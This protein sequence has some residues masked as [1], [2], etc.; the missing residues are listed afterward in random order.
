MEQ[1]IA[2]LV[3]DLSG[4]TALTE[5]HGSDSAADL[6]DKYLEIVQNSLSGESR[7]HERKGD[8]V[9]IVSTSSSD[10]FSTAALLVQHTSNEPNF[11]QVHGGLHWGKVLNRNNHYFG[12]TI[13]LA[14]R[15]A[16][17]AR[18]G[19]FW[20]SNDYLN[21]LKEKY[22]SNFKSMG[23]H[24]FKNLNSET[25]L[26]ELMFDNPKSFYIDPVCRMLVSKDQ[27]A[28]PHPTENDIFFC[29]PVCRDV[30]VRAK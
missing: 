25:E 26:F 28:T 8:E 16:G 13:N 5:M 30:Y 23:P 7:L 19:S 14:S 6:I 15:I 27:S 18:P 22:L 2:I 4:Y 3:A 1:N 11:L 21:T 24:S 29:S 10:L 20:C 17:K 9:M 12:T